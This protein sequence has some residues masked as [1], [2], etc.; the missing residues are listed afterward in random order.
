M[1]LEGNITNASTTSRSKSRKK[2]S[3]HSTVPNSPN[4]KKTFFAHK[5]D[6]TRDLDEKELVKVQNALT[7]DERFF[8]NHHMPFIK[9]PREGLSTH[10]LHM[11]SAR[12]NQN[13]LTTSLASGQF[14]LPSLAP[15][16]E[17]VP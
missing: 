3:K 12:K 14:N 4:S 2:G 16:T 8:C 15:I 11:K 7:K 1:V 10:S 9:S 5:K 6:D 17:K 13:Q